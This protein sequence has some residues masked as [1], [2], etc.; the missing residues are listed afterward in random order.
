MEPMKPDAVN[1]G[2][3]NFGVGDIAAWTHDIHLKYEFIFTEV[4]IK[5]V[6]YRDEYNWYYDLIVLDDGKEFP[7]FERNL[8]TIDEAKGAYDQW[9]T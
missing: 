5:E 2:V 8:R 3:P 6:H 4:L 9:L 7:C 1:A